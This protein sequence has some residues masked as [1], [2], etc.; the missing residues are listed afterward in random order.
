MIFNQFSPE[1][2]VW[3]FIANQKVSSS[4]IKLL[5]TRFSNFCETWKS[6]G[7]SLHGEIKFIYDQLIACGVNQE[8][9]CGRS[10]DALVRFVR[11]SEDDLDLLNRNRMGYLKNNVLNPFLFHEIKNLKINSSIS[12]TTMITNN[13]IEKNGEDLFIPLG[14]SPFKD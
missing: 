5:H 13:F 1:S 10:V 8:N 2:R 3:L 6:H 14:Q 9:L 12:S 4:Q 11:E 7:T